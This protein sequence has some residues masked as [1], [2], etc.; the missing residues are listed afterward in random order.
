MTTGHL[1][2]FLELLCTPLAGV[3]EPFQSLSLC[4]CSFLHAQ[5]PISIATTTKRE[6]E[7]ETPE[8]W[9][10]WGGTDVGR[11]Q[12]GAIAR[13]CPVILRDCQSDAHRHALESAER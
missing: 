5:V 4:V 12:V 2:A 13:I 11:P 6:T 3:L 10:Q 7:I 8:Q 9:E 1:V